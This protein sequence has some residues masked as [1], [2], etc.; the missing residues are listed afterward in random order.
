MDLT[1]EYIANLTIKE[2]LNI[3]IIEKHDINSKKL[4]NFIKTLN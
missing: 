2:W 4:K 1:N 3:E